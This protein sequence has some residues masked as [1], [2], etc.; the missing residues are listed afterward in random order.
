MQLLGTNGTPVSASL[1]LNLK[2]TVAA[3]LPTDPLAPSTQFTIQFSTNITDMAGLPLE[4]TNLF[5]FDTESDALNRSAADVV[6]YEPTN[7]LARMTGGPGM[8]EPNGRVILVNES[9]GAA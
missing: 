5:S 9:S 4:G 1:T 6:M 7:R 3:L 8:A 2:N